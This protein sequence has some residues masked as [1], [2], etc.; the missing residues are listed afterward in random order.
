MESPGGRSE[1][2]KRE[3]GGRSP[4]RFPLLG[5]TGSEILTPPEND[6]SCP[7]RG[8]PD[9]AG[10]RQAQRQGPALHGPGPN[11]CPRG[12][13]KSDL[14]LQLQQ[15]QR[16]RQL[17]EPPPPAALVGA[18]TSQIRKL[19]AEWEPLAPAHTAGDGAR[20]PHLRLRSTCSNLTACRGQLLRS[21]SCPH[22]PT[23]SSSCQGTSFQVT[24]VFLRRPEGRRP[25]ERALDPKTCV[26]FSSAAGEGGNSLLG[27]STSGAAARE[28]RRRGGRRHGPSF[29]DSR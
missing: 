23:F 25:Q 3:P 26:Q 18:P 4:F 29:T 11:S 22:P 24:A 6:A 10:G 27:E 12:S 17:P 19:R 16:Q 7:Q 15:R 20:D 14:G 2:G 1:R 9:G 21:S 5:I 13:E 8:K 28:D